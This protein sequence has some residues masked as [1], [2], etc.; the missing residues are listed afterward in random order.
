MANIAVLP[1]TGSGR[2]RAASANG[3]TG[4]IGQADPPSG[5]ASARLSC[6]I[7][8]KAIKHTGALLLGEHWIATALGDAASRGQPG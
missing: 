6:Q 7:P 5:Q 4:S 1:L 3:E 2:H 8:L